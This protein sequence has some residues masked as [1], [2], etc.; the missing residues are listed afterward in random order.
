MSSSRGGASF[1]LGAPKKSVWFII[2]ILCLA[3]GGFFIARLLRTVTEEEKSP[4]PPAPLW[5]DPDP[6]AEPR[7]I[8]GHYKAEG[9]AVAKRLMK[10]FPGRADPILLMGQVHYGHGNSTEAIRYWKEGLKLDP[11]RVDA[12]D[13]MG[14]IALRKGDFETAVSHWRKAL[15]IRPDMPG[16]GNSLARALMG[17]GKVEEAIEAL[18]KDLEISPRS[19]MSHFLLGQA[20]FQLEKYDKAREA[21]EKAIAIDPAC[22]NAYYNLAR[23][24][25]KLRQTA[26]AREYMKTFQ[27]LKAEDMKVLKSRNTAFD[28]MVNVRGLLATTHEDAGRIYRKYGR[29]RRAEEHWR[30][31]LVLDPKLTS[32][33]VHLA[34]LY[35]STGRIAEA[36]RIHEELVEL[37]PG[38]AVRYLA[39]ASL[40]VRVKRVPDAEKTLEKAIELTPKLS[41]G[42]RDLARLYL[43]TDENLSRAKALAEKAVELEP[44]AAN[45]NVLGWA[46]YANGEVA[47]SLAAMRRAIELDPDNAEYKRRYVQIQQRQ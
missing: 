1:P 6:G 35:E 22:T 38:N 37:E 43:R 23:S 32:C 13:G 20:Y 8:A 14:W 11:K 3:V 46:L 27:K 5:S 18:K 21:Y 7:E 2:A 25:M 15:E 17:L 28:D 16:V 44:S 31:A 41:W 40:Y 30:R 10:D 39:V 45:Y 36:I 9:L 29:S 42:Y 19:S 12:Y 24:L 4:L 26:K 47:G 33:R 34:S